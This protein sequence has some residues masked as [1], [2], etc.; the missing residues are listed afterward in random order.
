VENTF[1]WMDHIQNEFVKYMEITI[2]QA[3]MPNNEAG[4]QKNAMCDALFV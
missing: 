4:R 2:P 1:T 3:E